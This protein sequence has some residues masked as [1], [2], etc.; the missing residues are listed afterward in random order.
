M[1]GTMML[2]KNEVYT[3]TQPDKQ[4]ENNNGQHQ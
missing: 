3:I 2:E 4:Y 1:C